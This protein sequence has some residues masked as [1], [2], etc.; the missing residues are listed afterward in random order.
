MELRLEPPTEKRAAFLT[1]AAGCHSS[2]KKSLE[3]KIGTGRL[4]IVHRQAVKSRSKF[5]KAYPLPGRAA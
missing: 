1:P 3:K 2:A 4:F 5:S